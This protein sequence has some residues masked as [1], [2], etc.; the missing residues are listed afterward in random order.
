M[1]SQNLNE[2]QQRTLLD[3]ARRSIEFGLQN[4]RALPIQSADFD[5]VLRSRAASFVTLHERG[6]LRGCIGALKAY[7]PLVADV[8]EHAYAAAFTDPRFPP[9]TEAE[10]AQLEISISVLGEPEPMRFTSEAD[11][12]H[13]LRPGQDGLILEDGRHRGTFLP[14]VWESLPEPGD[15]WRHLKLKAS[16]PVD[17]WSDTLKVSRYT[18]FSFTESSAG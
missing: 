4:G 10:L 11:L 18:T 13:Q 7:Q 12:L 8:A 16:L 2:N 3:I 9:V 14:S 5:E 6:E 15:F 1:P 17:H